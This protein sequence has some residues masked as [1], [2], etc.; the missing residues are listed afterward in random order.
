[1]AAMTMRTICGPSTE[2]R[3]RSVARSGSRAIAP[4]V[5]ARPH[6]VLRG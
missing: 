6:P 5:T 2:N 4:P 1:M 3:F